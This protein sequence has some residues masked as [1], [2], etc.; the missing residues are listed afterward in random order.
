MEF[1]DLKAALEGR[2]LPIHLEEPV[3]IDD[4]LSL[5]IET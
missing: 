2:N 5:P 1:R 4:L 3:E